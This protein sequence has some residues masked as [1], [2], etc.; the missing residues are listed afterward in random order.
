MKKAENFNQDIHVVDYRLQ[1][2]ENRATA[3]TLMS[4]EGREIELLNGPFHFSPDPYETCLRAKWFKEKK[5]SDNG[6]P[7]PIDS[8]FEGWPTINVPSCW[9][10]E[11][12][13]L[14]YYESTALYFKTF[15]YKE[16]NP[17][18]R[19]FLHFEGSSYRTY[20]FLNG[21]VIG[22]HDGASTPFSFEITDTL[23]PDENRLIIAVDA[24]R[25]KDRV[26]MDNTD[27][28]NYGGIYRDIML[29]RT[30]TTYI[31]NFFSQLQPH[32]TNEVFASV[33]MDK[34]INGKAI[35]RITELGIEKE[36]PIK[37]GKGS[38]VFKADLQL[39]SPENPKLYT[40]EISTEDDALCENIG[41]R[42][43]QVDGINILLNGKPI[44]LK[45]ISVHED[46]ITLGKS[47][48]EQVIRDTIADLK[49]MH[50]NFIR[51][52]HYPHTR[53]F[54]KIADEIGVLLW[55]EIPVY[56][57]INF[58]NEATYTD[59][60]NQLA[61]LIMRDRNR[62]SVVIWSVGNENPDTD[63][64]LSFMS[65][66]AKKTRELDPTRLVSAACLVNTTKLKLE[67]RLME[68]LDIIGNNEYYGWY[69]PNFEDLLTILNNTDLT[70]PVIITEFGGGARA[71]N[72]GT[73]D[74]M[75]TEEFQEALYIKQFDTLDKAKYV[76]G[77]TPW[78]FYDF[79]AVRR[80]NRYQEG[81]NRKGLIDSDRKTKK[82]AF[83]VTQKYYKTKG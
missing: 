50:G 13:D 51:L 44:F 66:L 63:A 40:V 67:D 62:A 25:S 80:L 72:H 37:E 79:R 48:N 64:R 17:G 54:S 6:L 2:E 69:E 75:W 1:Y 32:T 21:K 74:T 78:I 20:V 41:F 5:I 61:E 24:S 27:W 47:T 14:Y 76:R 45:G 52:A 8:D 60:E 70:K 57:A 82:L 49:E 26:P 42:D 9:N 81:F 53:L 15:K 31:Q 55:E 77:M 65:S 11:C 30:P 7:L 46:H 4:I 33:T 56:W 71:G 22:M 16:H 18:E 43:I 3:E 59:A 36:I 10:T 68:H 29:V 28:F 12:K 19:V 83:Y 73:K 39:W 35:Y 38:I 58:V 23:I 34:K